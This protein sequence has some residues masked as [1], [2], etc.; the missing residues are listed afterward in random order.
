MNTAD[1]ASIFRRDL[2]GRVESLETR[3]AE[4]MGAVDFLFYGF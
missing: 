1:L 3:R 2:G 4:V